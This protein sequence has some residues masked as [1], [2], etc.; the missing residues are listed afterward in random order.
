MA[1]RE[2]YF[3]ARCC[4]LVSGICYIYNISAKTAL[5]MISCGVWLERESGTADA[6]ARQVW[7]QLNQL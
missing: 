1:A 5:P 7:L 4:V 2:R 3:L 6:L